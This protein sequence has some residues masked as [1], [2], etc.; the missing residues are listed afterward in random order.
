MPRFS[1]DWIFPVCRHAGDYHD[2]HDQLCQ[3]CHES[4]DTWT[5]LQAA[6]ELSIFPARLSLSS[7]SVGNPLPHRCSPL[8]HPQP[9]GF[10]CHSPVSLSGIS[11]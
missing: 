10:P 1:R 8:S 7:E 6:R 11:P 2:C 5:L 3:E 4:L 9:L